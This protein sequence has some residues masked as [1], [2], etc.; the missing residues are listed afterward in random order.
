MAF[1]LS[2]PAFAAI[3]MVSED[4]FKQGKIYYDKGNYPKAVHEFSK[5]LMADPKNTQAKRYLN[6][7]G[8]KGS[9]YGRQ[10]SRVTQVAELS[11]K[12]IKYKAK[13]VDLNQKNAQ[14]EHF[15]QLLQKDKERLNL[16][17]RSKE[18]EKH[19]ILQDL[20]S[21]KAKQAQAQEKI[22]SLKEKSRKKDEALIRIS[23]DVYELK[24]RLVNEKALV[25][26]KEQ[27]L[28][29]LGEVIKTDLKSARSDFKIAKLD[30]EKELHLIEKKHNN[31]KHQVFES[32]TDKEKVI[33]KVR[34]V[35]R[36]ERLKAKSE[37][38]KRLFTD[39]K[40]INKE[41]QI[42]RKEKRIIDLENTVYELEK[43]LNYFQ[44]KWKTKYDDEFFEDNAVMDEEQLERI[45]LI[46]KQ[47]V[48]ITKLKKKLISARKQINA[49]KIEGQE[50]PKKSERIAALNVQLV[51]VTEELETAKAQFKEKWED[52]NIL[53]ERLKD[54]RQRLTLVE[55]IVKSKDKQIRDLEEQIS[56][57]LSRFEE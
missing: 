14:K 8:I 45:K 15:N 5:A 39:F 1:C 38:N 43:E 4:L 44:E 18:Q 57:I 49:F 16:A 51:E 50:E 52:Y 9:L 46:R 21:Q 33:R 36:K 29:E 26:E 17:I 11:E 12:I 55:S 20:A 13:V 31:Y 41:S 24:D 2:L 6:T 3:S 7:L 56:G 48:I 40:M 42:A 25:G 22:S 34:E 32:D 28:R 47:D 27:Q 54:A 23:T 30:H 53:E 35:L 10:K 37:N 19:S